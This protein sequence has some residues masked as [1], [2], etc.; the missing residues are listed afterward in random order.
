MKHRWIFAVFLLLL[1]LGLGSCQA[2]PW[3]KNPP[4][5]TESCRVALLP[6]E[7]M[8]I[9]SDATRLINTGENV[10]FYLRIAED[11]V[12][13]G[14]SA[15]GVYSE[16]TGSL[17]VRNVQMSGMISVYTAR[18]SRLTLRTDG[19]GSVHL[20]TGTLA[21]LSPGTRT[22]L[23]VPAMDYYFVGWSVGD[24]LTR[25][26]TLVSS[27]VSY[28]FDLRGDKTLFANFDTNSLSLT[29]SAGGTAERL[30]GSDMGAEPFDVL[31]R[32][33]PQD[34]YFF[35]GWTEDGTYAEGKK[36]LSFDR[37]YTYRVS[38]HKKLCANFMP[39]SSVPGGFF[40][41]SLFAGEG[42]GT[43]RQTAGP[44]VSGTPVSVTV[45]ASAAKGYRFVGWSLGGYSLDAENI[46]STSA[47]YSFTMEK[48]Q[49]LYA[50][51]R[52]ETDYRIV[53][54]TGA[55]SVRGT[56][57]KTYTVNA[58]FLSL[59]ACQQTLY[60][61]GTFVRDG[62]LPIGYST[63]PAELWDY[64]S[65][66]DIPGFSN[67]GGICEVP[68]D[69]A[70]DLYVV[71]VRCTEESLFTVNASGVITAYR[72]KDTNLAIP[73]SVNGIAVTGIAEGVFRGM[74]IQRL[75]LP[76]SLRSVADNAF[77]NCTA[78]WEVSFFDG[79][80]TVSDAGFSGCSA[81]RLIA[82]HSQQLPR[83]SGTEAGFC[84]KYERIRRQE[85]KRIIVLSGS[86]SLNGLDS[87]RMQAAFPGYYVVNYGTNMENSSSFFLEAMSHYIHEGDIVIHAPEMGGNS[88]GGTQFTFKIFRANEWCYDIFRDVDMRNYQ[89]FWNAYASFRENTRT[90]TAKQYQNPRVGLDEHGDLTST[91]VKSQK[92]FGN[93]KATLSDPNTV[94]AANLNRVNKLITAKG[95]TLLMSFCTRD[96]NSFAAKWLN[97]EAYASYTEKCRAK[98]DYPVI[99]SVGTYIMDDKYFYDSEWH[100]TSEGAHIRT[101]NLIFDLS[102]YFASL[103]G[104]S[105]T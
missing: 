34:G 29:T 48:A 24:L 73:A 86:S 74:K 53:Y 3:D 80:Q 14:N 104:G 81:I 21:D 32:A 50:N 12:Y 16:E 15:G 98:L 88:G 5:D 99:S 92:T 72:G 83:Y 46:V 68:A 102:R 101:D 13:L 33:T 66:N 84:I 45:T 60:N 41:L 82:L 61:D 52:P 35:L 22:V 79:I 105:G 91:R 94:N 31:L 19:K 96:R 47:A 55:G 100:C 77:A 90:A 44:A 18:K 25:G 87:K 70:L 11:Y 23:A 57:A 95:G 62:Y 8:T 56:G 85:G 27:D 89:N 76:P 97:E 26:G 49:T 9:L 58:P 28:V 78:L 63:V 1:V 36:I 51:F 93:G 39:D 4:R 75:V 103:E 2:L 7:G 20:T 64:P 69:G 30:T 42:Q 40:T 6:S 38:G 59:Y 17:I 71:W 37:E 43:A 65:V 54:H 67:M 10:I